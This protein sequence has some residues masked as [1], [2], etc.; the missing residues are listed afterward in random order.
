MRGLWQLTWLELKIFLREPL[1]AIGAV[2][3]PVIA[4]VLLGRAAPRAMSMNALP[5]RGVFAEGG[6]PVFVSMVH[7]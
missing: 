1:G 6:V 3:F 4:F 5:T 2:V 7:R